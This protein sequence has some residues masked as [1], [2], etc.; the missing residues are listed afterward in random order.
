MSPGERQ[1]NALSD[2]KGRKG[3]RLG[4]SSSTSFRSGGPSRSNRRSR[5]SSRRALSGLAE[6][7][8]HSACGCDRSSRD[9]DTDAVNVQELSTKRTAS[10]DRLDPR[11]LRRIAGRARREGLATPPCIGARQTLGRSEQDSAACFQRSV[12]GDMAAD[13]AGGAQDGRRG[14]E[15]RSGALRAA[16]RRLQ[17][18]RYEDLADRLVRPCGG[19]LRDGTNGRPRREISARGPCDRLLP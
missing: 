7:S 9:G 4:G 11:A 12:R 13:G 2:E 10:M 5:R 18:R 17:V 14:K 16:V 19:A 15:V 3:A 1:E 8:R 6:R